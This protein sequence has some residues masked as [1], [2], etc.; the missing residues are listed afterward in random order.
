M[1]KKLLALGI[2][3]VNLMKQPSFYLLVRRLSYETKNNVVDI[4]KHTNRNTDYKAIKQKM[5]IYILQDCKKY[6]SEHTRPDITHIIDQV[7]EL[8]VSDPTAKNTTP[9]I[10]I[11]DIALHKSNSIS[12]SSH[13]EFSVLRA[14]SSAA[15]AAREAVIAVNSADLYDEEHAVHNAACASDRNYRE[16]T[17]SIYYEHLI[18]LI[19]EFS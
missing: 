2:R 9:F 8:W 16:E 17:Y 6:Y 10:V 18:K 7:C 14:A 3:E 13:A 4:Y 19:K 15:S 11:S 12:L 1:D 5:M